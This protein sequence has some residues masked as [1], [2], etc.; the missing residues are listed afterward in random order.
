MLIFNYLGASGRTVCQG[1]VEAS[2]R[3]TEIDLAE[4]RRV[5]LATYTNIRVCSAWRRVHTTTQCGSDLWRQLRFQPGIAHDD[6]NDYEYDD[7][8]DTLNILT[9]CPQGDWLLLLL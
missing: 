5:R 1:Q 9:V 6:N 4:H 7:L 8:I 3:K 2:K